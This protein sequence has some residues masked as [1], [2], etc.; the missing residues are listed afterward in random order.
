[1][2][3]NVVIHSQRLTQHEQVL[4]APVA[5][6]RFRDFLRAGLDAAVAV[7]CQRPRVTLASDDVPDNQLAAQSH[8]IGEH[9]GELDVHLHQRLLHALDPTALLDQQH[10]TLTRHRPQL[11]DLGVWTKRRA[12]QT[13]A[14][15]LLQP[16]AVLHVALAP[17]DV[18]HL[19]RIDQPDFQAALFEHF[20]HRDPVHAS[21]LQRY[22]VHAA[23]EQP[24]GHRVQVG[25]HRAELAHRVIGQMRGHRHPVARCAH[26]NARGIGKHLTVM[27]A[28][29][30]G[31]LHNG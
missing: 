12:Q 22:G 11:A 23:R 17:G 27:L 3:G 5:G 10:V 2:A 28:N 16:L 26:I 9:L 21:G 13:Q 19:P 14:H 1:M 31:I 18:L 15:E 24:A 25:R 29:G 7:A 6:Q 30:H 4:F 20:K 8:H